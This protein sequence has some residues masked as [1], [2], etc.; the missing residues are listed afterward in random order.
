MLVL[1]IIQFL[2]GLFEVLL[3]TFFL[4][5]ILN[6]NNKS[7]YSSKIIWIIIIVLALIED[8]NRNIRLYSIILIL[9]VMIVLSISFKIIYN[10]TLKESFLCT[11]LYYFSLTLLDMFMIFSVSILLQDDRISI[12]VSRNLCIQRIIIL[13]ITRLVMLSIYYYFIKRIVNLKIKKH[14]KSIV[15]I[16]IIEF[17]GI[18]YY[19][20][21]Y[22]DTL[23]TELASSYYNFLMIVILLVVIL[24]GYVTYKNVVEEKRVIS[25]RTQMLERNYQELKKYY[26]KSRTLF[27]D[28]NAHITLLQKHLLK[29]NID[30]AL[31]FLEDILEPISQLERK[32]YSGN[33]SIDIVLN[34]KIGEAMEKDI[35][36]EYDISIIDTSVY[37]ISD[38]KLFIVLYNLLENAIEACEKVEKGKRWI[39]VKIHHINEMLKIQISNS[40]II[41]P[42]YKNSKLI[43]SKE[44][45]DLHGLGLDSAREVI[46]E[47]GGYFEYNY[48]SNIFY[49]N[50]T[51]F[52]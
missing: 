35:L 49:V 45:K 2:L 36:T 27:H 8:I 7:L 15:A 6:L 9:F 38:E 30:K 33:E 44:N 5:K 12:Y 42:I 24:A 10:T 50:I 13:F 28:Y 26:E 3:S 14:Y 37:K 40:F 18:I 23:V 41:K 4:F 17:I 19:Q 32:L 51:I 43:T 20:K 1:N 11:A 34:Y 22:V 25:L 46:E 52:R 47:Y 29:G 31:H 48:D 21:I 39:Y 16:I